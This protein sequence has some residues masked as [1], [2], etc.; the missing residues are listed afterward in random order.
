MTLGRR[1]SRGDV[2]LV[3]YPF[4][5][6]LSNKIRPALVAGRVSGDDLILAFITG[7]IST[8]YPESD[9]LLEP[10]DPEFAGTGLK[11]A[12]VIR[13]SKLATLHRRLVRRRLGRVGPQTEQRIAAALRRVFEL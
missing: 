11:T 13:L 2:V 7:Q 12:S 4:T 10:A 1:L 5:D 8:Q 9:C 3:D 6:L